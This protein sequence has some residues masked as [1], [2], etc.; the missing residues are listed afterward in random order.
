M[1]DEAGSDSYVANSQVFLQYK[2]SLRNRWEKCHFAFP[3][4]EDHSAIE[5]THNKVLYL[6][7]EFILIAESLQNNTVMT[8]KFGNYI[9]VLC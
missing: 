1:W 4:W 5:S 9:R 7:L 8:A 2:G 6:V 3:V